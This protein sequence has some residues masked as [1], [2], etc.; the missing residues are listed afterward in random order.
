MSQPYHWRDHSLI[1]WFS[2]QFPKLKKP[3]LPVWKESAEKIVA[4]EC[5]HVSNRR[6]R[7][8]ALK[9]LPS[10]STFPPANTADLKLNRAI[11]HT[12]K[13]TTQLLSNQV[14]NRDQKYASRATARRH[15]QWQLSARRPASNVYRY[16]AALSQCRRQ[17]SVFTARCGNRAVHGDSRSRLRQALALLRS[18]RI[19]SNARALSHCWVRLLRKCVQK[20]HSAQQYWAV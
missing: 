15:K 3:S 9:T 17:S 13:R 20:C 7:S 1:T 11:V 2:T 16:T 14:A 19:G 8:I 5:C 6:R 10:H 12:T 4:L 18:M